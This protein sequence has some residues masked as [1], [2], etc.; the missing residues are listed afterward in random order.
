MKL[1]FV[2]MASVIAA[3]ASA[4]VVSGQAGVSQRAPCANFNGP[5]RIPHCGGKPGVYAII[6]AVT[7]EPSAGAAE[8]IRILGTFIVPQPVSSGLHI[9]PQRGYLYFSL[10][11]AT[12]SAAKSDWGDLAAAAGTSQVV[13]FSE[14]WVSRPDPN[15]P[16]GTTNTSLVVHVWK[17]GEKSEAEPYP[18]PH[19]KGVIKVFDSPDDLN[20]RFGKPSAVLIIELRE[21]ARR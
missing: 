16:L 17:E 1:A 18:L 21:A 7:F 5:G 14:Y 3:V 9:A 4:A 8:R 19:E 15:R 2:M 6:D 10:V 12:E 11:P 13:G 20:P